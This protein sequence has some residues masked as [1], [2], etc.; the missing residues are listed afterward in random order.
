MGFVWIRRRRDVACQALSLCRFWPVLAGF[1]VAA[2]HTSCLSVRPTVSL[3]PPFIESMEGYVSFR[4]SSGGTVAK[5][6]LSFIYTQERLGRIQ[7]LDA[8]NRTVALV[9][10]EDDRASCALPTEK[11]YWQGAWLTFSERFLGLALSPPEVMALLSGQWSSTVGLFQALNGAEGWTLQRDGDGRIF[12]GE[13]GGFGFTVKEFFRESP[14]PRS[15][16]FA[17]PSG[18]GRLTTLGLEFNRPAGKDAFRASFLEDGRYRSV[19]WEE[20]ESFLKHER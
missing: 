4:F 2:W 16:E 7:V 9:L 6:R 18:G 15:L 20:L 13:K 1:F 10:I 5:S 19:T 17:H 11:V 14:V 8:I 3:P 12:G